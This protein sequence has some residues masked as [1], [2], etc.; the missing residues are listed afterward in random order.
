MTDGWN[1]DKD[2]LHCYVI[3][4][5]N[6]GWY[7]TSEEWRR[8]EAPLVAIDPVLENFAAA[9]GLRLSKNHK[10]T[11]ERSIAWGNNPRCLIQIY[12]EDET[13]LLWNLWLCGSED[14]ADS[15]YW[16]KDFAVNGEPMGAFEERL[17]RL[18]ENAFDRIEEWRASPD[19]LEFATK[20]APL[21][22]G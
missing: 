1:A 6:G 16:R 19:Q 12:L 8:R 14:R 3:A 22:R 11:P 5:A 18:L 20:L 9:H 17:P 2:D 13:D 21:P 10:E 7:G 15:R 4:M